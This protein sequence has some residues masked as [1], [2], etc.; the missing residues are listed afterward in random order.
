MRRA[1]KCPPYPIFHGD[2][3]P[4]RW[5]FRFGGWGIGWGESWE[6]LTRG[7]VRGDSWV[8][9]SERERSQRWQ[10]SERR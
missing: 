8:G 1:N 10:D 7:Y 5:F 4:V 9:N 6:K 2:N 3:F